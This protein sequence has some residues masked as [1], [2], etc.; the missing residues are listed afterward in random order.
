MNSQENQTLRDFLTQ[1]TQAQVGARDAEAEAM[2]NRAVGQQPDAAY[3]LVQRALLLDR[4]LQQAK[5]QL[6]SLQERSGSFVGGGNAWGQAPPPAAV[7]APVQAGPAPGQSVPRAAGTNGGW[8]GLLGSAA[9]TAAGVAG[10]AFLFQGLEG[11]FG[12]HGSGLFGG[13]AATETVEDVTVNNY[14]SD[15]RS[16][17]SV[18]AEDSGLEPDAS[19]FDDDSSWT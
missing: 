3:L 2:I 8:G 14:A 1:L 10:G 18:E 13:G 11:L 16:P 12:H 7:S 17:G 6:A 19:D 15:A 9:A 4:A 5:A